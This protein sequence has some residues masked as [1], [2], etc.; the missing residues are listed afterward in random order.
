MFFFS[1]LAETNNLFVS[2]RD[3]FPASCPFRAL[4][5]SHEDHD[6]GGYDDGAPG[7]FLN[8]PLRSCLATR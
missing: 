5:G 1:R 4:I 2:S 7:E 6:V 3:I 8:K